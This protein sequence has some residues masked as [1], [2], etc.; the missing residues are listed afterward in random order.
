MPKRWMVVDKDG[1]TTVI[2]RS[3]VADLPNVIDFEASDIVAII[4]LGEVPCVYGIYR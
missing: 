3:T 2:Q 1:R 4:A